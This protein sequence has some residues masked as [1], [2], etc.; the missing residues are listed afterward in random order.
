MLASLEGKSDRAA[1]LLL[2]Y[3]AALRELMRF[4]QEIPPLLCTS[5]RLIFSC[6][7]HSIHYRSPIPIGTPPLSAP[8]WCRR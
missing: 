7:S 8:F 1:T 4:C 6:L 2:T 3:V 5:L